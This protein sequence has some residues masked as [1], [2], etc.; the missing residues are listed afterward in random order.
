M[1]YKHA[2]ARGVDLQLVVVLLITLVLVSANSTIITVQNIS[3]GNLNDS[4][5]TITINPTV[6]KDNSEE[7]NT[8]KFV[9]VL[10]KT[11]NF[12]QYQIKK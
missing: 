10:N 2:R 3:L 7:P 4:E 11:I 5:G 9:E 1:Y 8:S 6:E 12:I